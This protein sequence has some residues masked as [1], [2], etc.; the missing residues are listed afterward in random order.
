VSG[1]WSRNLFAAAFAA[2]GLLPKSQ[3]SMRGYIKI[4]EG[5]TYVS[6]NLK[7]FRPPI[8]HWVSTFNR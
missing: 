3:L 4:V 2:I 8:R 5:A 1:V 6:A 7:I